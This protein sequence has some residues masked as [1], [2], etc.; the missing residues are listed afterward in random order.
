MENS[1]PLPYADFVEKPK[2]SLHNI[3]KKNPKVNTK[4]FNL[5]VKK[6]FHITHT[7][8]GI[9]AISQKTIIETICE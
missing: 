6:T 3:T 9:S 8:M 1:T 4:K 2:Q 5:Y 7:Q